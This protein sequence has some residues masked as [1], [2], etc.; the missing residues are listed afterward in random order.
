MSVARRRIRPVAADQQ[1]H[2]EYTR[3]DHVHAVSDPTLI[4]LRTERDALRK[5]AQEAETIAERLADELSEARS[6]LSRLRSR[7][8][9]RAD[10]FEQSP[11]VVADATDPRVADGSDPTVLPLAL[12]GL[13]VVGL[14]VAFLS[15]LNNGV[16][17]VFTV[18]SV[19]ATAGL[20]WGAWRTRVVRTSVEIT[21]QGVVVVVRGHETHRFD[22][23]NP[24][25]RV[26]VHGLVDDPDWVTV[27]PR[28]ALD[29]CVVDAS[30][31]EPAEFV[32]ELRRY[33]PEV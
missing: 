7:P 16:L 3:P 24:D 5:R 18:V 22:L 13:G 27:F 19:L 1:K 12:A 17:S 32:A 20:A 30:M 4:R 25:T 10:L 28:R 6:E 29:S 11:P 14:M 2:P 21:P 8:A 26:E 31:V 23:S 33:R 9:A 15:L